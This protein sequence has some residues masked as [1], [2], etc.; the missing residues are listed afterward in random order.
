MLQRRVADV[1]IRVSA[2]TYFEYKEK[3][4]R[5]LGG[6]SSESKET[7]GVRKKVLGW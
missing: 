1:R 7:A 3:K 5:S 2:G 6:L 4:A